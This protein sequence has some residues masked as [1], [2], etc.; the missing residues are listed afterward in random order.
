MHTTADD[1]QALLLDR[2]RTDLRRIETRSRELDRLD[3]QL[4][5]ASLAAT[6]LATLLAGLTAALG[7]LAGE[8]PPAWRWTCGAIAVITA[9]SGAATGAHQR[10]RVPERR[11]DALACAG[12]LRGLEVALGIARRDP[13]EAARE[14][15]EILAQYPG[16]RS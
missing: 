16:L 9:L 10:F 15:Q 2:I 8:G 4:M 13:V 12:R 11:A 7:P 3:F 1:G 6:T 5:A 14:Y